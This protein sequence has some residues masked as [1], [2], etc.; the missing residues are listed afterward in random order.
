MSMDCLSVVA[1]TLVEKMEI[2]IFAT[3][4]IFQ[5]FYGGEVYREI[6]TRT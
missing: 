4:E 1:H 3:R 6:D 2:L 5:F